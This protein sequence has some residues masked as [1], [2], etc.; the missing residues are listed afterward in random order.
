M[1]CSQPGA[2]GAQ[3]GGNA[4]NK[5]LLGIA[6]QADRFKHPD[7]SGLAGSAHLPRLGAGEHVG[8]AVRA[9]LRR[10]YDLLVGL[11]SPAREDETAGWYLFDTDQKARRRAV[12]DQATAAAGRTL[13]DGWRILG[14]PPGT[15]VLECGIGEVVCPGVEV[16][17]P[18]RDS[19]YLIRHD[20]PR[21]PELD[22]ADLEPEGTRSDFDSVTGEPI[23]T[24]QFTAAGAAR[25]TEMS[26]RTAG[27]GK[28]LSQASNI[29]PILSLQHFAIVLDRQITSWPS[30]DWEAYP[31]GVSGEH[32]IQ[33]TGIF[34]PDEARSLATALRTGALPVGFEFVARRAADR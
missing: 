34:D 1:S 6:G 23:V 17:N 8:L 13:L 15:V 9:A 29:D 5:P 21:A 18:S 10:L 33:I 2:T 12:P 26:A 7:R 19:Y 3:G 11:Q 4:V 22:G 28:Q 27:R 20:P 30:I 25:F 31:D 16:E 14:T 24:M 32:G